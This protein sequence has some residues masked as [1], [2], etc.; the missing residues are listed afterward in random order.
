MF[1]V[2]VDKNIPVYAVDGDD[3]QHDYVEDYQQIIEQLK[4]PF[5]RQAL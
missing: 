1:E 3:T 5:I 4:L 2:E